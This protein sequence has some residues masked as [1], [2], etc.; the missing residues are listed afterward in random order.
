MMSNLQNK[1][2]IINDYEPTRPKMI[3]RPITKKHSDVR[4]LRQ[5][6]PHNHHNKI[7]PLSLRA[8]AT[9]RETILRLDF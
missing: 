9:T 6:I 5:A 8:V 4:S 3:S 2:M 7:E 1:P